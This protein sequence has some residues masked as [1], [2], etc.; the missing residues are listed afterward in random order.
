MIWI[1]W[2]AIFSIIYTYFG[3]PIILFMIS[4][5]KR[6]PVKADVGY[7]PSVTL[8]ITVHNEEKRIAKK[9][10]NTLDLQYPK[11]RLE[12]LF[13]SDASTDTT[14]DIIKSYTDKGLKLIRSPYRGGKELAQKCAIK[15]ASGE[16]IVFSDVA[17]MLE[18][19]GIQKIAANFADNSVGCVS[20]E[21]KYIDEQGRVSGEGAYVKY[22]MWLRSFETQVNSVVGLSGSFFAARRDVC[23]NWP[24]HIPSDF[25]TLM[26]S[27]R[28]GYRGI[29]DPNSIGIYTNI[30][31]ENK[32][33]DRKVRTITR[34]IAALLANK[35]LLNP[36]QYG[37]FSWQLISHK[38]L[39]WCVPLFLG[40]TFFANLVLLIS[41]KL[42]YIMTFMIQSLLY[43]AV[44]KKNSHHPSALMKIIYYFVEVNRAIAVAWVKYFKGERFVTWSPSKR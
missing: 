11:D 8:I 17:T 42:F 28:A 23:Q 41:G 32:E 37:L 19:N 34:G 21:D 38:M 24:V 20:S 26:N 16:I 5:F 30:S 29:S 12:I 36:M 33:F 44:F 22:E 15:E 27:I 40:I 9:I 7:V 18:P 25:N 13:T 35:E 1:F 31:D 6:K 10:N 4:I 39:R 14:E 43:L 3:Y 2:L